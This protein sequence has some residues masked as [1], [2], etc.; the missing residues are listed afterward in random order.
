[1][2]ELK[3]R[4]DSPT[5]PYDRNLPL[6]AR[7]R[8]GDREAGEELARLNRPLVYSIA[9]RFAGRGAD[10]ED[11][12]ECGNIGLVKAINTFDFSRE[13]AFST[14]AV[15]L[16]FGEIRR[17]LRDD[18]M[19]KVSREEKRLAAL[20]GAE[21]ERRAMA[22]EDTGIASVAAA[23]GVSPEDAAGALFASSP[24]HSL[25]ETV[26]DDEGL[27]LG[28]IVTDDEEPARTF[29]RLALRLAIEKLS[30]QERKII[31]LRYFRDLSQAAVAKALGLT[32]VKVSREEKKILERL[33]RELA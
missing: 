26:G 28:S 33:R 18:G 22:G 20:I 15:P 2:N 11:L 17:F 23:V 16:I 6:L 13:C 29:D 12:V 24:V 21:R 14:Y 10:M 30:E 19:I 9:G 7:Y 1:M 31:L 3:N 32:Q 27:T 8:A 4:T 5:R 25:E